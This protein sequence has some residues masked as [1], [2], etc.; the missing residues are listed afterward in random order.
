MSR[1]LCSVAVVLLAAS[2]GLAQDA[3]KK[4]SDPKTPPKDRPGGDVMI[5][6]IL[7]RLDRNKDEKI[8]KDEAAA[9]PRIKD[10][11]DRIDRDKDGFL[12]KSELQALARLL[13]PAGNPGMRPGPGRFGPGGFRTDPLDFDAIDKNADGRLIPSELRGSRFAGQFDS[14]DANRDGKIDPKEWNTFHQRK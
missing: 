10:G 13:G 7:Q 14:I 2:L 3:R 12:S 5:N 8:S 6:S 1:L 9:A 11:F 4:K